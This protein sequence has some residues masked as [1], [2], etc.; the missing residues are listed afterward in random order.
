MGPTA[1]ALQRNGPVTLGMLA[2]HIW[3]LAG[4]DSRSDVSQTYLNPFVSHIT[5]TK[6]KFTLLRTA[7][8]TGAGMQPWSRSPRPFR[9]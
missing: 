2:T 3:S 1:V 9:S 8:R 6:T 7:G 5:T 4:A